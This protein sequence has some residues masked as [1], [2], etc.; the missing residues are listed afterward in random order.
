M[1]DE[2]KYTYFYCEIF[3]FNWYLFLG[4]D[5]EAAYKSFCEL[6]HVDYYFSGVSYETGAMFRATK[7]SLLSF[8]IWFPDPNP[9]VSTLVHETSHAVNFV[10]ENK[11]IHRMIV[12]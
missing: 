11:E 8:G 3:D 10:M 7:G 9:E 4:E 12:S 2:I 5:S 6:Q 1:S